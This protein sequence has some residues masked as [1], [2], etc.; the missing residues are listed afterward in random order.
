MARAV[1]VG[2]VDRAASDDRHDSEHL[3][4]VVNALAVRAA[5]AWKAVELKIV[6]RASDSTIGCMLK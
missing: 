4:D 5:T 2:L 1:V 3:P 6:E